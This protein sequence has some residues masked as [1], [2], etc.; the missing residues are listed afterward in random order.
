[1]AKRTLH[2]ALKARAAAVKAAH[3]HLTRTMPGF[4][5]LPGHQQLAHTQRHVDRNRGADLVRRPKPGGY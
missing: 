3:A 5:A 1:M 4:R 2:P